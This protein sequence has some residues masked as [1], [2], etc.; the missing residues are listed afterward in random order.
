MVS[1]SIESG[2]LDPYEIR[3]KDVPVSLLQFA[4]DTIFVSKST[5]QNV[6]AIKAILRLFELVSGLKIKFSKSTLVILDAKENFTSIAANILNCKTGVVP[7]NYLGISVGA[8]PRR[9]QTWTS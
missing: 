6:N 2:L 3:N 4:D 7:L 5:I 8:N 1:K 9:L